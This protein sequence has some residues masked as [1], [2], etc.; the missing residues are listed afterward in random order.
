VRTS[1]I[2]PKTV[3]SKITLSKEYFWFVNLKVYLSRSVLFK[4]MVHA[5]NSGMSTWGNLERSWATPD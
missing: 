5:G 2:H 1:P 4:I 3:S